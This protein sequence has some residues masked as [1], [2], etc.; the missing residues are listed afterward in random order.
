MGVDHDRFD[1]GFVKLAR[2]AG[3]DGFCLSTSDREVLIKSLELVMLGEAVLPT[4]VMT[5]LL[6]M[7]SVAVELNSQDKA[8]L[9]LDRSDPRLRKLSNRES[10]ILNCLTE[11][12]PNKVIA[13]K[14]DVAEATVKVHVKSLLRKIGAANRTQA[15]MWA[16]S[17]L[18]S[19]V[20]SSLRA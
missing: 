14:L 2:S 11:G 12:A 1:L 6:D 9:G 3:V 5:L 4:S 15:A 8:G 19:N 13:R 18:P 7:A 16:T 20:E 17:H 10:Q